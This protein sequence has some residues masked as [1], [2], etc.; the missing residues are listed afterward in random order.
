MLKNP[1]QARY[2][3]EISIQVDDG[4]DFALYEGPVSEKALGN[5]FAMW[6]KNSGDL[7]QWDDAGFFG[8]IVN[9]YSDLTPAEVAV[10]LGLTPEQ[11]STPEE[12]DAELIKYHCTLAWELRSIDGNRMKITRTFER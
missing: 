11:L 9:K 4:R 6:V 10:W 5:L 7:S 12:V 8:G 3:W 1:P 2:T